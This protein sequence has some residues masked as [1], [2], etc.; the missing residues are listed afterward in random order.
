MKKS[1]IDQGAIFEIPLLKNQGFLYCKILFA[2]S[3]LSNLGGFNTLIVKVF[4]F[5]S[6]KSISNLDFLL[7]NLNN[8]LNRDSLFTQPMIM[9]KLPYSRGLYKWNFIGNLGLNDKDIIPNFH[10]SVGKKKD[11]F[12]SKK[13][14]YVLEVVSN[15]DREQG[16][17]IEYENAIK[18][19]QYEYYS[20][21]YIQC[22]LTMEF[23]IHNK[24]DIFNFISQE[25]FKEKWW[26]NKVLKDV[27]DTKLTFPIKTEDF[28][29]SNEILSNPSDLVYL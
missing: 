13:N 23:I 1:N 4:D 26:F 16:G 8:C 12:D 5:H 9:N 20:S 21:D 7:E 18:L 3:I 2:N 28:I 15:L 25:E 6:F 14:Y 29:I 27:L 17:F 19:P 10:D 24:E 11:L 22:K